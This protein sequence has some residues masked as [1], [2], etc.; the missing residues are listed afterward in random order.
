MWPKYIVKYESVSEQSH[1][2][3]CLASDNAKVR[4]DHHGTWKDAQETEPTVLNY[5]YAGPTPQITMFKQDIYALVEV[6]STLKGHRNGKIIK[7]VR[8]PA[9]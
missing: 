1:P 3:P 2:V 5:S 7:I 9:S 4:R 6:T 8:V